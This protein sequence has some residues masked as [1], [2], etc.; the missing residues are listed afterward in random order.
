ML[1]GMALYKWGV[2]TASRDNRF[3][4]RCIVAGTLIGVPLIL[5][6]AW[7]D[8]QDGWS[9]V[10]SFFFGSQFNYWGSLGI[11]TAW[12]GGIM[13][14]CR[15]SASLSAMRRLAAVG[16]MAFTNYILET[17]ICTTIFYGHGLGLFAKLD[18]LQCAATVIAVWIVVFVVSQFWMRHF[19]FGPLEWLWRSLTYMEREPFRRAEPQP[20]LA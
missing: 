14:C 4:W 15:T 12:I 5:F 20:S 6:G 9:F 16:R 2:L 13:L 1:I 18:R 19:C 8:I 17:A 3:Y 10:H 7:R 11:S